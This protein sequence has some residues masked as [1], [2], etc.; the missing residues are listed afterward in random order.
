MKSKVAILAITAV[1]A[2]FALQA[3]A[4]VSVKNDLEAQI[5]GLQN[6]LQSARA[7]HEAQVSDIA[8][9]LDSVTERM[10]VTAKDIADA[11]RASDLLKQEQAK[12]ET[13]L[14]DELVTNSKA[15]DALREEATSKLAEVESSASTQFGAVSTEVQTVKL[16]LDAAK[17]DLATRMVDL[18]DSLGR[19]IAK[20]SSEVAQL[21]LRGERDY[22]EFDL[23]KN[24]NMDRIA[25][26]QVQL[27]KADTK[28]QKYDVLLLVDDGKI[29][30]KG[31]FINEPVQFNVG[32][33]QLRYELVVNSVDKDRVRG[34]I[35]TPRNRVLSAETP[36]FRQ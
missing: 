3:Y 2:L 15:V 25:D 20:N 12:T 22:F 11:R 10:G 5:S 21:R 26:I 17:N 4:F 36:A 16:D 32:R 30:K 1:V 13:R 23:R 6:E 24:K 33:D 14:R 31:Q 34:Y 28:N 29:E 18:R 35:S 8:A 19:E 7:S 9:V 27:K